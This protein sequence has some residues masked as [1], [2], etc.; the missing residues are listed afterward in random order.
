MRLEIDRRLELITEAVVYTR[1]V[2]DLGMPVSCYAK[3]LREP[4]FFLWEC[5]KIKKIQAARYVS[6]AAKGKVYGKGEIVYDHCVPYSIVQD[7][8][9]ALHEPR[10][11]AVKEILERFVVAAIITKHEDQRLNKHKLKSKMPE[12]WDGLNILARYETLGIKLGPNPSYS[13]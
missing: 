9:L 13:G 12:A 5:Y 3:A 10:P 7:K 8:L 2:R 1:M 4:I 11:S 6:L